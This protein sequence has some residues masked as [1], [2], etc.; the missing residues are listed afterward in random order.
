MSVY[1]EHNGLINTIV[2]SAIT[3]IGGWLA[4]DRYEATRGK[5]AD[6]REDS[7]SAV[8]ASKDVLV[9]MKELLELLKADNHKC[10]SK[11]EAMSNE[12]NE[13]R[14]EVN[15][16]RERVSEVEKKIT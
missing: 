2:I 8:A 9:M 13:L 16:Y 6:V 5:K 4:K 3:M 11:L 10:E 1:E 12:M 15:G 14:K 7:S